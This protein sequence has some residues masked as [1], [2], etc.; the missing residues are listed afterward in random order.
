MAVDATMIEPVSVRFS[1]I[2]GNLQG[3]YALLA[4]FFDFSDKGYP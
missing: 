4:H 1:L 3:K 2:D